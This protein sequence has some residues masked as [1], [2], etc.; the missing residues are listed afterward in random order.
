MPFAYRDKYGILHAVEEKETAKEYAAGEVI[1]YTGACVG[2]YP[3]VAIEVMDYG[4]GKIF[5]AGNEKNGLELSKIT[6]VIGDAAR[7]LLKSIGI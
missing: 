1:E 5:L 6:G 2:G 4:N 3:A 7:R